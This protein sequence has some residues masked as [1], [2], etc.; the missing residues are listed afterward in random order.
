MQKA[1]AK[2]INKKDQNA[3][4]LSETE[5]KNRNHERLLERINKAQSIG[6]VLA[7]DKLFYKNWM[8]PDAKTF[9][10]HEP[11]MWF[12]G[13]YYPYAKGGPLLLD[14]PNNPREVAMAEKKKKPL[15]DKGFRYYVIDKQKSLEDMLFELG[16]K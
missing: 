6:E 2:T 8:W 15:A 4:L 12:V 3:R 5:A 1:Y 14:N 16:A 7:G 11:E 13:S 10:P 9:F